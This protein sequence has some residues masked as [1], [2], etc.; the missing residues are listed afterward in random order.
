[1]DKL[2]FLY[3]G[4]LHLGS[5]QPIARTDNFYETTLNKLREIVSIAKEYNV[6]SILQVGDLFDIPKPPYNII[7]DFVNI[8]SSIDRFIMV[9][10][11]HEIPGNTETSL[12]RS[13]LALLKGINN[14]EIATKESPIIFQNNTTRVAITGSRYYP[15]IDSNKKHSY[16]IEEKVGDIH[17]HIVHGMLS[18]KFL[19]NL[20]PHTT[21][22]EIM[23]TQ[24]DITLAGHDHLGFGIV[25]KNNKYFVNCGAALRL[26]CA[27]KE[28]DRIPSVALITIENKQISI[29]EIPLKTAK[30]GSEVLNR[31]KLDDKKLKEQMN[32][33]ID[34]F[35]KE[36]ANG[37]EAISVYELINDIAIKENL[38]EHIRTDCVNKLNETIEE[39]QGFCSYTSSNEMVF[40][41]KIILENFESHRYSEINCSKGL[42]VITG[43][44]NTGKSSIFKALKWLYMNKPDRGCD[45]ITAGEQLCR[46]TVLL[47]NGYTITREKTRDRKSSKKSESINRY[48]V[49]KPNGELMWD[50]DEEVNKFNNEKVPEE[51]KNIL[52][53]NSLKYDSDT[54]IN[55]NFLDQ[56]RP[57]FFLD[58]T[59]PAKAKIMGMFFGTHYIDENIRKLIHE[60]NELNKEYKNIK[61]ESIEIKEQIERLRYLE[62]IQDK[63]DFL[64]NSL[65][66]VKEL[67][68]EIEILNIY[69]DEYI[70]LQDNIKSSLDILNNINE[71]KNKE[72]NIIGNTLEKNKNLI[73]VLTKYYY[74]TNELKKNYTIISNENIIDSNQELL[75]YIT[76][77][78]IIDIEK[79][80]IEY[81][82]ISK[83]LRQYYRVLEI[84]D[85]TVNNI[86][87]SKTLKLN[88]N[89][90]L[91]LIKINSTL[92]EQKASILKFKKILENEDILN[93]IIDKN[94]VYQNLSNQIKD[95]SNFNMLIKNLNIDIDRILTEANDLS[96]IENLDIK[97]QESNMVKLKDIINKVREYKKIKKEIKKV[98]YQLEI[99]KKALSENIAKYKQILKDLGECPICKGDINDI[100]IEKICNE[101]EYK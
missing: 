32:L 59:S 93:N 37:I 12:E 27:K 6:D 3:V 11:N 75:N 30:P 65:N 54:E 46:V 24:A 28:I 33:E 51:I 80:T 94:E 10:G 21:I 69:K 77:D 78:Q 53:I 89:N 16:I 90:S 98:N 1:M 101:Y 41:D 97:I 61:N 38:E 25:E 67:R 73:D 72:F 60:E 13:V 18:N 84:T 100:D 50:K 22:D 71:I 44:S 86:N 4:D 43:Q 95:I 81:I 88:L 47:S 74:L 99:D 55:F 62:G 40:I 87:L 58:E 8:T 19:G 79:C 56:I 82:N 39:M 48:V 49:K 26:T 29:K 91:E 20:I 57:C 15:N 2:S 52:K 34:L 36:Q 45:F 70:K 63:M 83:E 76:V 85:N 14:I 5:K 31:E 42:N 35:A 17:I 64:R 7:S 92:N 9:P 23:H 68:Q 96:N 66:I